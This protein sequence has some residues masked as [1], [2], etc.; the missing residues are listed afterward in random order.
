MRPTFGNRDS[1]DLC[2]AGLSAVQ[3]HLGV[4]QVFPRA[5]A[6]GRGQLRGPAG[7]ARAAGQPTASKGLR[8]RQGEAVWLLAG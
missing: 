5:L 8:T 6:G 7:L 1:A 3:L 4:S 2:C